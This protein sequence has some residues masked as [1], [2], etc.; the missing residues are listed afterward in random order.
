[1]VVLGM[2]GEYCVTDVRPD[3][4]Q[5]FSSTSP[6]YFSGSNGHWNVPPVYGGLLMQQKRAL[7]VTQWRA[8]KEASV[9]LSHARVLPLRVIL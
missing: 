2:R 8:T 4:Q 6:K 9:R 1:M 3:S 5:Q 7:G